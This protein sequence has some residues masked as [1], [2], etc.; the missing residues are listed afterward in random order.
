MSKCKLKALG[1]S[2]EKANEI[3]KKKPELST[4]ESMYWQH[5]INM[6]FVAG[7][8]RNAL[9]YCPEI[10][11]WR[12]STRYNTELTDKSMFIPL[13]TIESLVKK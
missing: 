6:Y 11:T 13:A 7:P 12:T 3:L 1:L 4:G 10:D 8:R 5:E 9:L 2:L